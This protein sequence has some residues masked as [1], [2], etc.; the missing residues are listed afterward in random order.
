MDDGADESLN[1]DENPEFAHLPPL[2][3]RRKIRREIV[4]TINDV[5]EAYQAPSIYVDSFANKA[6]TEYAEWLLQNADSNDKA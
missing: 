3:K 6:A 4:K 2:D 1:F 5:R